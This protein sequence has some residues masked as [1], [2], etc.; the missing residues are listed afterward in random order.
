MARL[1]IVANY[2]MF[3]DPECKGLMTP[4]TRGVFITG[5][6]RDIPT[7]YIYGIATRYAVKCLMDAGP[8]CF[9]NGNPL[10]FVRVVGAVNKKGGGGKVA[11]IWLSAF[12]SSE[13]PST[14]E[15]TYST[16]HGPPAEV[17]GESLSAC[18]GTK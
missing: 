6:Y 4:A 5:I 11:D 7:S 13:V 8:T 16:V 1:V 10:I 18:C 15:H 2:G 12:A 14:A 9:K 3:S 17:N